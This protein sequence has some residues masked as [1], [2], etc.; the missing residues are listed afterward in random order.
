MTLP[1]D[2]VRRI[3]MDTAETVF[4]PETAMSLDI[5][6]GPDWSGDFAYFLDFTLVQDRDR[7][8]ALNRRF[9]LRSDIRDRL[10]SAG[11]ETF[12]YVRVLNQV[13]DPAD[14]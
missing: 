3:A 2:E 8:I 6:A 9:R 11:D 14:G 7:Q 4:G 13:V 12:P 10:E 5:S 1:V